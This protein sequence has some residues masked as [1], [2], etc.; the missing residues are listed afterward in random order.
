L[1]EEVRFCQKEPQGQLARTG[2]EIHHHSSA[3]GHPPAA[4]IENEI[5]EDSVKSKEKQWANNN[6][7]PAGISYSE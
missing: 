6:T 7:S 3:L 1:K 5:R 2:R 4:E